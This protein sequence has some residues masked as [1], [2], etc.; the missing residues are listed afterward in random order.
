MELPHKIFL[1]NYFRSGRLEN[2]QYLY[3]INQCIQEFRQY[4]PNLVITYKQLV[5]QIH[6]CVDEFRETG[7]VSCRGSGSGHNSGTR[8][9]LITHTARV[10]FPVKSSGFFKSLPSFGGDVKLSVPA[11]YL[12]VV[13]R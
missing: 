7:S 3:S 11:T 5:K 13:V 9:W 1:E 12:V 10:R 8:Y 6:A 4:F 2:G